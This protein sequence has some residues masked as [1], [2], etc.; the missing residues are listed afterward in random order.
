MPSLFLHAH[1]QLCQGIGLFQLVPFRLELLAPLSPV[2]VG[3]QG[4]KLRVTGCQMVFLVLE[5]ADGGLGG[6]DVASGL[7]Q[8]PP[9]R[10]E[11]LPRLVDKGTL[12]L[13]CLLSALQLG[14]A[15][16]DMGVGQVGLEIGACQLEF[17]LQ[18]RFGLP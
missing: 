13:Q 16:G 18:V 17:F 1:D 5:L 9:C 11:S 2:D 3:H 14:E 6:G 10:V 7:L 15:F 4:G 8:L 12:A